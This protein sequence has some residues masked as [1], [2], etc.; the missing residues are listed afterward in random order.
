MSTIPSNLTRVPNLLA[1]QILLGSIQGTNQRLLNTQIQLATGKAVNR[2]SDNAIAAS[3]I[4]VLDDILERRDQRLRNLSHAEAVLNTTDA[5]LSNASEILLEAKSIGQGQLG[6]GSD[7][8]TRANQARVIDSM[9]TELVRIGN[10]Q[11]QELYLFGGSSTAQP[12]F[13]SLLGGYQYRGYGDGLV[14]DTGL[15]HTVPITT[16][17]AAVFG[18]L[19]ARVQGQRD[20]DPKMT[21]NTRLVD[22]NGA[23][24]FGCAPPLS[25]I[26]VDVGGTDLTVDLSNAHTVGDVASLL[27]TAIATI[28]PAATVSIDPATGNRFAIANN[29]VAITISDLSAPAAAADLGLAGTYNI[30][31]GTG[32]DVNPK[33][34]PQTSITSLAAVTLPLGSIRL[35][36]GGQ[37]RDL[38]LSSAATIQ[39]IMN[40]VAGLNI[41]VRVEIAPTADRLNFVNELS[42]SSMSIAEVAGASAATELGVRSFAAATALADFNQGRGVQYRT[43]SVNP[44]TGLPDPTLDID[45][46]VTLKD[47]RS[48]DVD[49]ENIST[50]QDVLDQ[51]N[52]AAAGA[53]ILP[54]DF[55]AGLASDG[56]G[57]ELTDNTAG[58]TTSVT[59]RNGS[60]AA[61]DLGILGSTASAT[62]TGQDRAT[63]A[64]DSVFSHLIWLRNALQANDERGITIATE[65]LQGDITRLAS[66]RADVGVRTQRITAAAAREE[67]LKIQDT[68]LKSQFQDL[69]Y[70]EAAVRFSQLQQ[71]LQAALTTAARTQSLS[72]LDFLR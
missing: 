72:L 8:E 16:S 61:I 34:T 57:I 19:S 20:L 1:S 26:H 50:V 30:A 38:D 46:R 64:V 67:D 17:G 3:T 51:I 48:F 12:P 62:L 69:D 14:T 28:D 25:S 68:S 7:A 23:R 39:D 35:T 55:L 45:F 54:A 70:T 4:G 6:V 15:S 37:T 9:L 29:T 43:G 40:L 31:G 27:Q 2:P 66:A 18:A 44:V 33:L 10:S 59:A 49:L 63:V 52:A 42:G 24:G 32:S 5:A 22:L 58:T 65:K 71:Q 47:G 13:A 36:N 53:G 21:I 41:G 11:F 56:N 60:F